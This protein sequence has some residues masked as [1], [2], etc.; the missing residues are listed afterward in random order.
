MYDPTVT[1]WLSAMDG[2]RGEIISSDSSTTRTG[3]YVSLPSSVSPFG[4]WFWVVFSNS[5]VTSTTIMYLRRIFFYQWKF[6]YKN[7]VIV[8]NNLS[9]TS[10]TIMSV[11]ENFFSTKQFMIEHSIINEGIHFILRGY[12]P[13][14][15][16]GKKKLCFMK[17]SQY[18]PFYFLRLSAFL[19]IA[20]LRVKAKDWERRTET[21]SG[22]EKG[23]EREREK[24]KRGV[25]GRD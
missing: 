6:I 10:T 23:R 20:L 19:H 14:Y 2:E 18:Q 24:E 11:P 5:S 7:S 21:Q 13:F 25:G 12:Q 4:R 9:D 8:F 15:L 3:L 17:L 1:L 22:R 16:R